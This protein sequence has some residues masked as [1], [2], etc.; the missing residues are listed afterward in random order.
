MLSSEP[1][2]KTPMNY[3][4][5]LSSCVASLLLPLWAFFALSTVTWQNP[6]AGAASFNLLSDSA[7]RF[8]NGW[9]LELGIG[10]VMLGMVGLALL[11]V[12]AGVAL[13]KDESW[14]GWP[15]RLAAGLNATLLLLA[16]VAIIPLFAV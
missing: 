15:V 1:S 13:S 10:I 3:W 11:I 9:S 2:P 4:A 12:A 14:R 7:I 16:I 5:L 8:I 6:L